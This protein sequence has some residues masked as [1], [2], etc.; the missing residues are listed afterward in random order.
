[1]S[2]VPALLGPKSTELLDRWK[3]TIDVQQFTLNVDI[4]EL[5]TIKKDEPIQQHIYN[6]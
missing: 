6:F 2:L 3:D 4:N 5:S 1:M